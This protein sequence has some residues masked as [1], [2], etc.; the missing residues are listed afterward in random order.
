MAF[1]QQNLLIRP[2]FA[3]SNKAKMGIRRMPYVFTQEGVAMLSSVLNSNRAIQANIQI[4][5][6]FVKLRELMISHKEL[7]RKIENIAK[8]FKEHDQNFILIFKAIQ[9][10]LKKPEESK[11]K[12]VP[13]GF[14]PLKK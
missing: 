5:R 12:K 11:K 1:F 13:I 9:E 10:L 3:T 6:A 7:A 2:L 4:M 14:S 8:K